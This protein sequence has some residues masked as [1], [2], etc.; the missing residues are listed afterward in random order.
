MSF[1][2]M[3][4]VDSTDCDPGIILSHSHCIE[5]ESSDLFGRE[6]PAEFTVETF[7]V[8]DLTVSRI[9]VVDSYLLYS[10][11]VDIAV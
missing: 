4:S 1:M 8:Q 9:D 5:D 10:I 7:I 6:L 11:S 3:M 2:P